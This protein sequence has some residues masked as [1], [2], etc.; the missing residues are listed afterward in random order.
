MKRKFNRIAKHDVKEPLGP[1]HTYVTISAAFF[2]SE[3]QN[4]E[5]D[6]GVGYVT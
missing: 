6:G 3:E 4:N 1:V 2:L 5:N